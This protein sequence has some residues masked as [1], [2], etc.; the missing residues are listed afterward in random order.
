MVATDAVFFRNEH[1]GIACNS[2]LGAWESKRRTNLTLFKPGVYWDD[3]TRDNL[4]LD[5][6]AVFKSRGVSG[7]AFS[8]TIEEI[9][10]AFRNWSPERYPITR[11]PETFREGWYPKVRFNAG[12]TMITCKQA[13][14]RGKWYLAGA[15]GEHEMEQDSWPGTKR[16]P[17]EVRDGVFWSAPWP[18]L[19]EP[20]TD[21]DKKF[22]LDNEEWLTEDGYGGMLIAEALK[23]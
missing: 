23:G 16:L 20:S 8:Q 3:T 19:G 15:V 21:Y 11:D 13:L 6:P 9:D 18:T 5:R 12:F 1:P 14:A 22:G 4:R 2:D 7:K 17:G 10:Q